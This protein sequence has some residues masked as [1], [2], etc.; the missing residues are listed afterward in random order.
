MRFWVQRFKGIGDSRFNRCS[1]LEGLFFVGVVAAP[2]KAGIQPR[3]NRGNRPSLKA[4]AV[5]R[6]R[7]HKEK[8]STS[9]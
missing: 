5:M 6:C 2:A 8:K 7:S 1:R 9:F 3:Q 4:T